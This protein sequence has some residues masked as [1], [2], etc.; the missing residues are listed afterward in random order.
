MADLVLE[1]AVV[2]QDEKGEAAL[3]QAGW[4]RIWTSCVYDVGLARCVRP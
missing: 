4:E 2:R 3:A 1:E